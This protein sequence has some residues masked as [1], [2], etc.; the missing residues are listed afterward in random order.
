[1]VDATVWHVI[2]DGTDHTV[3]LA[4]PSPT[5]SPYHPELAVEASVDCRPVRLSWKREGLTM[6]HVASCSIA[7]HAA[8]LVSRPATERAAV[9]AAKSVLL[10]AALAALFVPHEAGPFKSGTRYRTT[11]FVDGVEVAPVNRDGT[12]SGPAV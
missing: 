10:A 2:L 7:G 5:T 11:L 3:W 4:D 6:T 12:P 9:T 1:M 8:Q